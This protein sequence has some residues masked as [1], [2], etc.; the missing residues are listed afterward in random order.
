MDSNIDNVSGGLLI[1]KE[2][3]RAQEFRVMETPYLIT[4]SSLTAFSG[5]V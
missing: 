1:G 5:P 4:P 2:Q 3:S